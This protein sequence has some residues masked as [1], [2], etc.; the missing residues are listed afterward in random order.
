MEFLDSEAE[1]E[2]EIEKSHAKHKKATI[3]ES[4]DDNDE[5]QPT[6]SDSDFINDDPEL[7]N[8][9]SSSALE[10]MEKNWKKKK[11]ERKE[12]DLGLRKTK[13]KR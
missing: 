10:E 8:P 1:V 9:N 5:D 13:Q 12:D 4:D 7:D 6:Q 11:L 3:I 2:K